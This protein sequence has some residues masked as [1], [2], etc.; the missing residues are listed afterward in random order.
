MNGFIFHRLGLP[1]SDHVN[2]S[3]TMA[4]REIGFR[5]TLFKIVLHA[6]ILLNLSGV[7]GPG[8]QV[9][10]RLVVIGFGVLLIGVG[11]LLPRT[12]PNLAVGIRTARTLGS[13]RIWVQ[14]H[15]VAGYAAVAFGV[16][17]VIAG[18]FLPIPSCRR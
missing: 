13:R 7:L 16:V 9:P 17:I 3:A 1:G 12:R 6:F 10:A 4:I 5:I 11:D 18:A 14:L 15:R 8:S 2:P